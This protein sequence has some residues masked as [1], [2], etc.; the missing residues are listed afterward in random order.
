MDVP[1]LANG[2]HR[3]RH[4]LPYQCTKHHPIT[5]C[6]AFYDRI[7]AFIGEDA[8]EAGVGCKHAH[9]RRAEIGDCANKKAT[10]QCSKEVAYAIEKCVRIN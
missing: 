4:N 5:V 8:T 2:R 3:P 1:P 7:L 10:H 9:D 6:K